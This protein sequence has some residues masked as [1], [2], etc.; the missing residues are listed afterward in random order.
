[1]KKKKIV[2][3]SYAGRQITMVRRH[4]SKNSQSVG[5]KNLY[6][7]ALWISDVLDEVDTDWV[8]LSLPVT[9]SVLLLLIYYNF[10]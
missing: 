6:A 7:V 5:C 10:L 3:R 4:M 8:T 9:K 2:S 1:M